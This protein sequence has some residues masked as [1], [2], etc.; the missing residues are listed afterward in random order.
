MTTFTD[1]RN[2]PLAKVLGQIRTETPRLIRDYM[3]SAYYG[4]QQRQ[5]FDQ[6]ETYCT[7]IGFARTGSTMIGALLDAHPNVVIANEANDLKYVLAGYSRMQL[8]YLLR[9]SAHDFVQ[10]KN[11]QR[12]GYSYAVPGYAQGRHDVIRVIGEKHALGT[13][14]RLFERPYLLRWLQDKVQVPVKFIHIYRNPYDC[15]ATEMRKNGRGMKLEEVVQL[16][17][18]VNATV[19]WVRTRV[20]RD[21][22]FDLKHEDFVARPDDYMEQLFTFIGVEA[23][24][25]LVQACAAIVLDKPNRSRDKVAWTPELLEEVAAE[26]ERRPY[27]REYTFE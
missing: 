19:E 16:Y 7:L 25:D 13:A 9:Q 1:R 20:E 27:L 12:S 8:Y 24:P 23:T 15:I 10:V 18:D 3:R 11:T 17:R 21:S 4:Y 22:L 5:A 26:I 6:V 2:P 14:R